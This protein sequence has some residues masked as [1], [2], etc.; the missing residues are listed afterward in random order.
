MLRT[1]ICDDEPPALELMRSLLAATGRVEVVAALQNVEEALGVIARGGVELAVFDIE[2]PG[3]TGVEAYRRIEVEPKPL[4][5]FATA[6]SEYAVEAFDVDA[7]DFVL[8]PFDAERV[9][10][11]VEKAVRLN[12]A[13]GAKGRALATLEPAAASQSAELSSLSVRDGGRTYRLRYEEVSWIE[14]AGDYC[15]LHTE[16]R[17]YAVR[18]PMNRL[19]SELPPDLF[20]RVHR[21]AIV[22]MAWV[23]EIRPLTKGEALIVLKS[24]AEVK[25]SRTYRGGVRALLGRMG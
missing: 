23:R 10:R 22:S 16:D 20:V 19:E 15:L 1:V 2:M 12:G 21:S 24:G 4:L 8:K 5:I 7:I 9:G 14:A 25:S 6:H 3:L 18:R 13:I 11:A 17:E